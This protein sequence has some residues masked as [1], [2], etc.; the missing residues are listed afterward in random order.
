[1][2][3]N[4]I[5]YNV[6]VTDGLLTDETRSIF[7]HEGYDQVAQSQRT[8]ADVEP[9]QPTN[10]LGS[11]VKFNIPFQGDLLG[12]VD[13]LVDFNECTDKSTSASA[14]SSYAGWVESVGFAMID[15]VTL[16]IGQ[17]QV[18]KLTGDQL[19]LMNTLM[20]TDKTR[21]TNL[22]GTT[23]RSLV[24]LRA[25]QKER[26]ADD[27]ADTYEWRNDSYKSPRLVM[28]EG[29]P[30]KPMS[31]VIP[32]PFFFTHRPQDYL[33]LA[34]FGQ[35]A[36]V[37]IEVRFR[38]MHELMIRGS[39]KY[40]AAKVAS[41]YDTTA[42]TELRT[43][44]AAGIAQ[45][46]YLRGQVTKRDKVGQI[47]N[48]TTGNEGSRVVLD[49]QTNDNLGRLS[50]YQLQQ[51]RTSKTYL[52]A[53]LKS[54]TDEPATD[55]AYT[56][57]M[58]PLNE[59]YYMERMYQPNVEADLSTFGGSTDMPSVEF[60][61]G[62]IKQCKLRIHEIMTTAKEA[63]VHQNTPQVRLIKQW[64]QEDFVFKV[65]K[66]PFGTTTP[67]QWKME[68]HFLLPITEILM[69]I[70]KNTEMSSSTEMNNAPIK[71]DQGAT[72][73]NRFAFHGGPREP[74]IE[75]HQSKILLDS[76]EHVP[77]HDAS[78]RLQFKSVKLNLNQQTVHANLHQGLSRE[79][80]L[81]RLLPFLHSNTSS[82]HSGLANEDSGHHTSMLLQQLGELNDRK[83]IYCFPFAYQPESANP[84]GSLNMSKVVHKSLTLELDHTWMAGQDDDS[85]T[86]TVSVFGINF[87][88]L[89]MANGTAHTTFTY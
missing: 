32:L 6:G 62:P 8:I 19:M 60:S 72:C 23:G 54:E 27:E 50:A 77:I 18:E 1:M 61:G 63:V 53:T 75:A 45:H 3:T 76:V 10:Y 21:V 86:Y 16:T 49:P 47:V 51:S 85:E 34:M 33:P 66:R 12:P 31:L 55:T 2:T 5:Q 42:N 35:C 78:N 22:V 9:S 29:K 68:F 73:K 43:N 48:G 13:L 38:P 46:H 65:D 56:T 24:A 81:D 59:K 89:Q 37:I 67:L 79:Y 15:Y 82:T 25:D 83:E 4:Q 69:V 64:Q 20:R 52:R 80:M 58:Q 36:N 30:C 26:L 40:N 17:T 41:C 39:Y 70:R 14:K 87:N 11:T 57:A 44:T 84:S 28:D 7:V 74:N 88:W 71:V